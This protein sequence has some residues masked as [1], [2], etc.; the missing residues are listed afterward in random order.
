MRKAELSG[1]I[2]QILG[3]VQYLTQELAEF[4]AEVRGVA[5]ARSERD[6]S[7]YISLR[8]SILLD[9]VHRGRT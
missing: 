4:A 2:E 9:K 1:S 8:F 3:T 5:L 7:L 6:L